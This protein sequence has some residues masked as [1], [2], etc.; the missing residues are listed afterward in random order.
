[1]QISPNR[2]ALPGSDNLLR[3]ESR[4]ATNLPRI[5][6]HQSQRNP[7]NLLDGRSSQISQP[8]NPSHYI[9]DSDNKECIKD[10]EL[11]EYKLVR[12][13]WESLFNLPDVKRAIVMGYSGQNPYVKDFGDKNPWEDKIEREKM[14]Q[15]KSA[16]RQGESKEGRAG[17]EIDIKEV[18]DRTEEEEVKKI[19]EASGK[20]PMKFEEV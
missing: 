17:K 13:A 3:F 1:M 18:I 2:G 16:Q 15:R 14:R 5:L 19:A 11:H 4:N 8:G 10:Y 12:E 20:R 7:K 6:S 9:L